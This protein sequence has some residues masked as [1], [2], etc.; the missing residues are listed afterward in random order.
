MNSSVQSWPTSGRSW[1]S[2]TNRLTQLIR[3]VVEAMLPWFDRTERDRQAAQ[4]ERHRRHAI[5]VRIKAERVLARSQL[6]SYSRVRI[7]R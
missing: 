5:A 2:M 4:T 6:S 7:G 1:S 3:R